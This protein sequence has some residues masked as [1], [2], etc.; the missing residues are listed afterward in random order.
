MSWNKNHILLALL[1]YTVIPVACM[2]P[3]SGQASSQLVLPNRSPERQ[4]IPN[5]TMTN[6]NTTNQHGGT[7]PAGIQPAINQPAGAQPEGVQITTYKEIQLTKDPSGHT[8]NSTQCFSPDDKWIVYDSRNEDGGIIAAGGIAMVSTTDGRIQPLYQ[9]KNQTAFGPGVGAATFSPVA[10]RVLFLHGIR[11]AD[12]DHPYGMTRRTGVAIDIDRPFEPLFMDARDITSPFTPGALRGGTHA[13]S[14]SGNGMWIS[15]TYNDYLLEQMEKKGLPVKD[16]RTVGV[17]VTGKKVKVEKE[18]TQKE[19]TEKGDDLENNSGECYAF[20]IAKVSEKPIPGSDEIEKAFDE[21]WVGKAGYRKLDGS[22]QKAAIAFQGNLRTPEGK[23]KTEIFIADIPDSLL[24]NPSQIAA[25]SQT[26]SPSRTTAPSQATTAGSDPGIRPSVPAGI[27]V[28]RISYTEKGVSPSPRH[29]LRST[30]DG[31]LIGFLAADAKDIIQLFGISPNGGAVRQLT[32]NVF[33]ISGP[34]NFSPDGI[35]VAYIS[36][37]S[38]WITDLKTGRTERVTPTFTNEE[39]PE[40]AV[41]WS[42]SGNLLCYNR[43]VQSGTAGTIV[44]GYLQIF[45]LTKQ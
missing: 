27:T 34:F 19:K 45:L 30:P 2:R 14:W 36:D 31:T 13:H 15:F 44:G 38:V 3:V 23:I 37:N 40:G 4:P 11:N 25:S 6:L 28:R 7:Q 10:R 5:L 35:S 42:N 33:S 39:K 1:L 17:M 18:K 43:R 8:V 22:L 12:K 26:A 16:Q 21:G 24:S 29:W 32:N 20:L 9:T 41:V